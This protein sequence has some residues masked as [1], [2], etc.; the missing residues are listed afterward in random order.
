LL[1]VETNAS[2]HLRLRASASVWRADIRDHARKVPIHVALHK[3]NCAHFRNPANC[4]DF[5]HHIQE[6]DRIFCNY[7]AGFVPIPA[8]RAL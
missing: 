5:W 3:G 1:G 7:P 2:S 6:G 8:A 4:V